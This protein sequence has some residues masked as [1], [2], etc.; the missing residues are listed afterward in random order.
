MHCGQKLKKQKIAVKTSSKKYV[1][2]IV[3]KYLKNKNYIL[4]K[5]LLKLYQKMVQKEFETLINNHVC[6]QKLFRSI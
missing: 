5:L 4:K 1:L 6:W 2:Q 3:F